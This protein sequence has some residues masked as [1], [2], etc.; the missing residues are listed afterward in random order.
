MLYF[1]IITPLM[2]EIS[3]LKRDS[4]LRV[5][6]NTGGKQ[7]RHYL[8]NRSDAPLFSKDVGNYLLADLHSLDWPV[9][10]ETSGF[11][12]GF[13]NSKCQIHRWSV[14]RWSFDGNFDDRSRHRPINTFE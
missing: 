12:V 6:V 9:N 1:E 14:F 3:L 11:V 13:Q 8:L 7:R 10:W 2:S 4:I 5:N